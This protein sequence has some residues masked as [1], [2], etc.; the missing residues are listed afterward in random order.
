[1]KRWPSD[2]ANREKY[3]VYAI[4]GEVRIFDKVAYFLAS[5]DIKTFGRICLL[6]CCFLFSISLLFVNKYF[7]FVEAYKQM[8]L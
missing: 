5:A 3:I 8:L 7:C 1:M 4:Q 6:A 2:K